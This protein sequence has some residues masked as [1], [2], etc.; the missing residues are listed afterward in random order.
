M[1]GLRP[2]V[3]VSQFGSDAIGVGDEAFVFLEV[4]DADL[5]FSVGE[6]GIRGKARDLC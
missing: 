2:D 3:A 5:R 4:F 6:D 1:E